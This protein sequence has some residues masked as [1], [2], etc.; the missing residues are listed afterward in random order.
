M[1]SIDQATK[2]K[3][4]GRPK[5]PAPTFHLPYELWDK[6]S[7][8]ILRPKDS[9]G[10]PVAGAAGSILFRFHVSKQVQLEHPE[11]AR[12]LY[13]NPPLPD[14]DALLPS[15]P[16]VMNASVYSHLRP[17]VKAAREAI[18]VPFLTSGEVAEI[19]S[20]PPMSGTDNLPDVDTPDTSFDLA[21]SADIISR[22][23][24][25]LFALSTNPFIGTSTSTTTG[26][27]N[28][29]GGLPDTAPSTGTSL[30]AR[31][32]NKRFANE[33]PGGAATP[34]PKRRRGREGMEVEGEGDEENRE[35]EGDLQGDG[36]FLQSL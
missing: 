7:L 25:S 6:T 3:R 24:D 1:F 16:E 31:K 18:S 9:N 23:L 12:G 30:R 11:W 33:L 13:D 14:E 20:R 10:L 34:V 19:N 22:N 27:P 21:A 35:V 32:Q 2:G 4:K 15:L 36:A 28:A 29:G 5:Q 17:R 8:P 26:P